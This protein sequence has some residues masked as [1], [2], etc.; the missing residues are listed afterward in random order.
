MFIHQEE[1]KLN[2]TYPECW[3]NLDRI[4]SICK[5][6]KNKYKLI[7]FSGDLYIISQETLDKILVA[8]NVKE[9]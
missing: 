4:E 6:G 8:C 5:F 9:N 1:F 7:L 3:L 2:D